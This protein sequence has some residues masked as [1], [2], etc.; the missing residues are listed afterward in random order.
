VGCP[1]IALARDEFDFFTEFTQDLLC[2]VSGG[3]VNHNYLFADMMLGQY[4]FDGFPDKGAL[5]IASYDNAKCG[6]HTPSHGVKY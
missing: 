5:I 3:V 6:R 4:R 2:S 1:L